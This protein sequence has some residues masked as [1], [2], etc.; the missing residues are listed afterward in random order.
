M[1]G[2]QEV[3]VLQALMEATPYLAP[4]QLMAAAAAAEHTPKLEPPT[5]MLL[6]VVDQVH[7]VA[8]AQEE[9]M[10]IMVVVVDGLVDN[11][12]L[13]AEEEVPI[14]MVLMQLVMT[15]LMVAMD[16]HHQFLAHLKTM[17][18]AGG[19]EMVVGVILAMVEVAGAEEV[20][21]ITPALHIQPA[22]VL[23]TLEEAEAEAEAEALVA[24]VVPE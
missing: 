17:A 21:I 8:V 1:V 5:A 22:M 15:V 10:E 16:G 7:G 4:S 2:P 13:R 9:L 19:V 12:R 24:L 6:E 18:A 23:P 14:V 20:D 11:L 3:L